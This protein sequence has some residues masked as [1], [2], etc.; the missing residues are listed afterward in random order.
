MPESTNISGHLLNDIKNWYLLRLEYIDN[1]T[2][3][4]DDLPEHLRHWYEKIY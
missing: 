2:S 1:F 3:E 4:M